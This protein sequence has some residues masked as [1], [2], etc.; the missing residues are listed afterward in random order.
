[1]A[2]RAGLDK[3]L[4]QDASPQESLGYRGLSRRPTPGSAAPRLEQGHA[5]DQFTQPG[6][7]HRLLGSKQTAFGLQ[8]LQRASR[9][10]RCAQAAGRSTRRSCA[11]LRAGPARPRWPGLARPAWCCGQPAAGRSAAPASGFARGC[12]AFV[13]PAPAVRRPTARRTGLQYGGADRPLGGALAGQATEQVDLPAAELQA[14]SQAG[15]LPTR[16]V[17]RAAGTEAGTHRRQPIG[18]S[19]AQLGPRTAH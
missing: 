8:L 6:L 12:P 19:Q 18:V 2:A 10:L 14:D 4:V 9:A 11:P 13:G 3:G 1:M 7:H 5:V 17:G 16:A 15:G